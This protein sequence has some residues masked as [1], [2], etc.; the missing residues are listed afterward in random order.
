MTMDVCVSDV[1]ARLDS[2]APLSIAL[3]HD[4]V[5]L[6][7][8]NPCRTVSRIMVTLDV[9]LPAVR[10]ACETGVSL[11]VSHHPFPYYEQRRFTAEDPV[12]EKLSLLLSHDISV[13]AMHTNL[14][15]AAGGVNDVLAALCGLTNVTEFQNEDSRPGILGIGRIGTLPASCSPQDYAHFVRSSLH[16]RGLRYVAGSNPVSRVA[17]GSGAC[18][19]Y[20]AD[21]QS[22]GADTFVTGDVKYPVFLD[23]A[24][25]G[26]TLIDAGH[27]PTENVIC[28]PLAGMLSEFFPSVPVF[29]SKE[30]TDRIFFI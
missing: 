29:V 26:V 13:I 1:L 17:V 5:G 16:C 28:A 8:G 30:N 4:N 19:D 20:L 25:R 18:A 7:V 11:I 12:T 15:A 23:A 27:F 3:S 22:A 10:E 14:D 21:A 24:E 2:F 9:S 6:L